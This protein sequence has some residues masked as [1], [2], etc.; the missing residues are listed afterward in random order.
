MQGEGGRPLST[1]A[2]LVIKISGESSALKKDLEATSNRLKTMGANVA[3]VGKSMTKWAT[4]SMIAAATGLFALAQKTANAGD[5]IQKM[6][7]R[8]GF[9]TEALSEFKHA[10]ELS[11]S[12][13]ESM[14]KGVKRMQKVLFD[15][16]KGLASSNDALA[17]LGLEFK[18]LQGLKP[19]EQFS[20][21]AGALADVQ[22]SSRRAALAQEI[23]GR[24]GTEMLPMLKD[25]SAG[26]AAMRQEAHALGVVFDQEA[27]DAAAQFN[28][29]LLRLK[30]AVTGAGQELGM[31]L[32][33]IVVDQLV[34]AL[35]QHV[36]PLVKQFTGGIINLIQWFTELDPAWK[37]V[38]GAAA[39]FLFILGPVLMVAGKIIT[40][41]GALTPLLGTL[42]AGF[43]FLLSPVGLVVAALAALV[44]G[45]VYAWKT[46]EGFRD[47][48]INIWEKIK[49]VFQTAVDAIGYLFKGDLHGFLVEVHVMF[50]KIFGEQ[51]A[52]TIMDFVDF[53]VDIF[54]KLK[55]FFANVMAAILAFWDK[56]GA[57][58]LSFATT[59]FTAVWGIIKQS[60]EFI[61]AYIQFV[62]KLIQGFWDK[63]GSTIMSAWK[64]IWD[65]V[66]GVLSTAWEVIKGVVRG[67]L[68]IISGIISVFTGILTGDWSKVW[69]GLGSI[70]KG[71]AN[72]I[73]GFINGI[74]N[75]SERMVNALGRAV[76]R[77]PKFTVP[78]WVPGIGGKSFGLPNIP[79]ISLPRVPLLQTGTNYVPRDML[80]FLHKGEAVTPKQYNP[81]AGGIGEKYSGPM[82]GEVHITTD[83]PNKAIRLVERY[84]RK[85]AIEWG[86]A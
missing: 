5:E 13:I 68:N 21:L 3:N 80:A 25:G 53:A 1:V 60:L 81:A 28:D 79:A 6:S 18:S 62:L 2:S 59:T 10:A 58:I 49:D 12:S 23:F 27:A 46:N 45:L 83:D 31:K 15:A 76:N 42:G 55:D 39:G 38:I 32:I 14:E 61:W 24:A 69:S 43:A 67:A 70:V 8:T 65:V 35:Q 64:F 56:W 37:K 51:V 26:I 85:L 17:A 82:I 86:L 4:G 19:E 57:D 9:S 78:S 7:L 33:P 73:I 40:L 22:D 34:P 77:I 29:D 30:K 72:V 52:H 41:F 16:E 11:G 20:M 74:I 66:M 50:E 47:A 36:I 71:A 44:A 54:N 63:W 48:V 75:A 84:Q